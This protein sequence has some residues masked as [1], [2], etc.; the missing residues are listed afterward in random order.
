MLAVTENYSKLIDIKCAAVVAQTP[1]G[2]ARVEIESI[3]SLVYRSIQDIEK[4]MEFADDH[5]EI[6]YVETKVLI[7][8]MQCHLYLR[9]SVKGNEQK[10]L[11][12]IKTQKS[13][14]RLIRIIQSDQQIRETFIK[15]TNITDLTDLVTKVLTTKNEDEAALH[16]MKSIFTD[17]YVNMIH[18]SEKYC[19]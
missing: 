16:Y 14:S 17:P 18:G 19:N 6:F 12:Y 13:I 11:Y 7:I 8:M 9:Y 15:L 10:Q 2:T 1:N 4:Y 5:P 3:N